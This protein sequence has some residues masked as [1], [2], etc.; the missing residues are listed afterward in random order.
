[1]R[2]RLAILFLVCLLQDAAG[3]G[4][5]SR[6]GGSVAG[7]ISDTTGAAIAGARIS[8]RNLATGYQ[9]EFRSDEHG[10]F[11]AFDLPLGEY[12]LRAEAPGFAP[13]FH[14]GLSI[15][16][17]QTVHLQVRLAPA[18]ESRTVT[19][20]GQPPP[21]DTS[22]PTTTTTVD[23]ERIE[24]LPVVSRGYLNFVLLAPG[25]TP[26][27]RQPPPNTHS[28]LPDSGF[29]FGGLRPRSNNLSIDG[30]DNNDEYT[31]ASRTELSLETIREFQVVNNGLSAE[32]GG[33]SGGSINVVTRSGANIY[34]GDAFVF[35]QNGS[36]NARPAFEE[37]PGKPGLSRYRIGGALGGPLRRDRT[38]FYTAFEQEH[39]RGQTASDVSSQAIL[40]INKLLATGAYP[41]LA[42]RRLAASWSPTARAE[43]ELSA[44]L[45]HQLS[46]HHSLMLRY[47]FTNNR[48]ANDAFN[49]G[50]LTDASARGSAFTKDHVLVGSLASVFSTSAVNDLRFQLATRRV[51]SRTADSTGPNIEIP[52]VVNFGRPYEG[53]SARRENH[54][55]VSDSVTFTKGRHL[56][57]IG[58]T[59]NRIRLRAS[60]PDGFG[61]LYIFPDLPSFFAGQPDEYRQ[62]FGSSRSDFPVTATG[63]FLQD[64][65]AATRGLAVDAGIRYDFEHL[66][67]GFNQDT[68]NFSPRIGL[69]YSPA[70]T[71][72][73]RSG[74]GVF[75][76]RY[77]LAA[78]NRAL[79]RNGIGS[80][81]LVA[82]GSDAQR[83]FS[84]G[85]LNPPPPMPIPPSIYTADPRLADSYSQQANLGVEHL[86]SSNWTAGANF[87]V[88]RGVKLSRT[89]N[90]NLPPPLVL[91][92]S[93]AAMLGF[94]LPPPQ[95]IG[96]EVFPPERMNP[97]FGGIYEWQNRA[98]S[99]YKGLSLTLNRRLANEIEFSA[100]YT[101]SKTIDDASDFNEQ[102]QNPYD[103]RA[104]RAFSGFD[105]RHR[106][107]FSGLFD[108]PFGDE[109][110]G[111][112]GRHGKLATV[113]GNVEI[114]PILSIGSG[115]PVNP[116]VGTDINRNFAQ[117]LS[118]R[119]LG[120]A[121]NSLRLPTTA[122]LDLRILKLFKLTEHG[123]LD[124][125]AE[126]F[127]L[128][129]RINISGINPYFG[130]GAL[131][132]NSFARPI[133]A[134]NQRQV[135]FSLDFEF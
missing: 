135:Q 58:A 14:R 94:S 125:V 71:W 103:I 20:T 36:L 1:M 45:D 90:I 65:W 133:D 123:H 43:T 126:F 76:D 77:L 109:D 4:Q 114:A 12:E 40:A 30:V 112:A 19:V 85:A 86:I 60:V 49:T 35:V 44:R 48:V 16:I 93:N 9:R 115:H 100:A 55:Q 2:R 15:S 99:T 56:L 91:T 33:A 73:M 80:F 83:V 111:A 98:S 53:N 23:T 69:A 92:A 21:L 67:A 131:P 5:T 31:G 127:N 26:T 134:L 63:A 89:V 7:F 75:F 130:A 64:H 132:A 17:G 38:F 51:V 102:P 37:G 24:E 57:K 70:P 8:L 47:S 119:P 104:E 66:P 13:Y 6:T 124:L 72:V 84:A 106:F 128:V 62:G 82:E 87:L 54:Y 107:A 129:N 74:Y 39:A 105:Q 97:F 120:M 11:H 101:L 29:S 68:N 117:P 78:V 32:S 18:A 79:D 96:R 116:L 22:Q 28:Q 108:L 113:F 3:Y 110:E 122:Q 27:E 61:G 46:P 88:A 95:A 34:H 52:G 50:G 25:V 10:T 121:R 59:V 81:E 118:S 42:T 41:A